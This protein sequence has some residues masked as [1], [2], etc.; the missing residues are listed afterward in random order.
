MEE[1][2][3]KNNP[4]IYFDKSWFEN[5]ETSSVL[6]RIYAPLNMSSEQF[7]QIHLKNMKQFNIDPPVWI[8]LGKGSIEWEVMDDVVTSSTTVPETLN[9]C[10][11]S[12]KRK[13]E[14]GYYVFFST[15]LSNNGSAPDYDGARYRLDIVSGIVALYFGKNVLPEALHETSASVEDAKLNN[16]PQVRRLPLRTDGPFISIEKWQE[17]FDAI[18]TLQHLDSYKGNRIKRALA[19]FREALNSAQGYIFYW[20]ALDVLSDS[21]EGSTKVMSKL[22]LCYRLGSID[23]VKEKFGALKLK[24]IRNELIH[25]GADYKVPGDIERFVQLMFIDILR[26]ELGLTHVGYMEHLL[27]TPGYDLTSIDLGL[28]E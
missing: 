1:Q 21:T 26:Y 20:T 25:Q 13:A 27:N 16:A 24:N 6:V 3:E 17:V 7:K 4:F 8:S 22:Q 23:E 9:V 11:N 15:V 19:I 18:T 28:T 10:L 14:D 2:D 5:P 12:Y